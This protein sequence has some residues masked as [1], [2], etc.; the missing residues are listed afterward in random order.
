MKN[1]F[2]TILRKLG[3]RKLWAAIITFVGAMCVAFGASDMTTEQIIGVLSSFSVLI[4][5]IVGESITDAKNKTQVI[6]NET[7]TIDFKSKF[8]SRKFWAALVSFIT[9]FLFA[10][11]Y[12]AITID[13]IKAI[14]LALGT[15]C[16]YILGESA[17][18]G[19]SG[20][21]DISDLVEYGD[22]AIDDALD[23]TEKLEEEMN[24]TNLK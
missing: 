17:I 14:I 1:K 13:Q 10:I 20:Y 9:T 19:A 15:V 16:V 5:Y 11:G 23:K 7:V 3:S 8:S 12:D 21:L 24:I 18:D 6:N 2:N 22:D 4:I